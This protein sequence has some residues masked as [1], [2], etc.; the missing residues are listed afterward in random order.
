MRYH[1][2]RKYIMGIIKRTLDRKK[3]I[4]YAVVWRKLIY[5]ERTT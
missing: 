5:G 4:Y 1:N 2:G 3:I